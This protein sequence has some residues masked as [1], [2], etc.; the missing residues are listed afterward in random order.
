M[1]DKMRMVAF[2]RLITCS[3]LAHG[4]IGWCATNL[5]VRLNVVPF[6]HQNDS[7]GIFDACEKFYGM[8]AGVVVLQQDVT[9]DFDIFV[10]FFRCDMLDNNFVNHF[11][12]VEGLS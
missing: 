6:D 1:Y 3:E 10:S 4:V 2:G 5:R 11:F 12:S 8:R 9:E 7:A